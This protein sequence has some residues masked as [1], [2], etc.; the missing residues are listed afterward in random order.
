MRAFFDNRIVRFVVLFVLTTAAYAGTQF[1]AV[2]LTPMFAP[3]QRDIFSIGLEIVS[4]A[5]LLFV[6]WAVVRRM[7][8]RHIGELEPG[9]APA[10]LIAGA[11]LGIGLFAA[12]I[13]ALSF[14]GVAH[15][16]PLDAHQG[17]IRAG[18]M[19]V[20]SGIG[21]ELI[22]RGVV[23]RIFEEMFGSL[24]ALI[25]SAV[26][27]GF[28]HLGNTHATLFSAMAIALEAGILLG[29]CY[30]AVRNLW[31]PI[32]LHFGWN[33]AEGGIFG[34]A[35]SGNAFKG[36]FTTTMSGPEL[37]TGGAFGPEASVVA[38]AICGAAALAI[39]ALALRRDEWKPLRLAI[40]DRAS[41]SASA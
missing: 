19:A 24:T 28:T 3:A 37:L 35:V 26:L 32:G 20:L 11:A 1:A 10:N 25:V 6:Y 23:F 9:R 13:A 5:V 38:V 17:L 22:F 14:I 2:D 15:A 21:E 40:H 29:V 33:F 18:N 30:M 16:G 27:F 36:L 8:H 12:V 4:A 41:V 39:L 34:A 7:E 31:L